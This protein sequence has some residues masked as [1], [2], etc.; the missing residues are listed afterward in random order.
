MKKIQLSLTVF[1]TIFCV[2]LVLPTS[3]KAQRR[4]YLTE[5]EIELVRDNQ[6]IDLR[7]AVLTKA[8]DR[9]LAVIKNQPVKE[10][11]VWGEPPK[12]TRTELL[13]DIEKL[14]QKAIDDIDEVA[15]RSKDSQ[16]FPKAV[17]KLA[18]S[19]TE[20]LPQFKSFLDATKDGKES[21]SLL[22]SI[23]SCNSVIA[24]SAKVPKE[25]AKEEKK[26]KNE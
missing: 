10:K 20:Y 16:F 21:G 9:R 24:A 14:L 3:A 19:C 8:I 17:N 15:E 6:Q 23:E 13:I 22:G 11:E 12:G 7:I 18:A 4:D 5:A 25:P 26:K 1:A 2:A